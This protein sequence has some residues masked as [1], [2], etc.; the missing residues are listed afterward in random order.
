MLST[1]VPTEGRITPGRRSLQAAFDEDA[2]WI[3]QL[4]FRQ[5]GS[6][7]EA[8]YVTE[9]VFLT[10]AKLLESA[11]DDEARRDLE[12]RAL[13]REIAAIWHS[14]G[15]PAPSRDPWSRSV[16]ESAEDAGTTA[17]SARVA[18]IFDRLEPLHRRVLELRLL[19]GRSLSETAASLRLSEDD[20]RT[21]QRLALRRAAEI[22]ARLS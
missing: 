10:Q 1:T 5:L 20:V 3:Y 15:Q 2:A 7:A 17:P 12:R 21:L 14:H 11:F 22:D 8:E 19:H 4:A 16:A 13:H 6:R 9:R 18:R